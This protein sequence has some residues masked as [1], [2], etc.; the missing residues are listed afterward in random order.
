MAEKIFISILRVIR[1]LLI[2]SFLVCLGMGL[3]FDQIY[4][5]RID[6]TWA[7][8][9]L[10]DNIDRWSGVQIDREEIQKIGEGNTLNKIEM[11]I[12][13]QVL[14][15]FKGLS[16]QIA[17]AKQGINKEIDKTFWEE[18][19]IPDEFRVTKLDLSTEDAENFVV[20]ADGTN[21]ALGTMF[22]FKITNKIASISLGCLIGWYIFSFLW[23]IKE[24][25]FRTPSKI[26]ETADKNQNE[27]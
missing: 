17:Y 16:E 18:S 20:F 3:A 19:G 10:E 9:E 2:I 5:D 15:E 22:I 8:I 14:E 24:R 6:A 25:C 27:Q 23:W 1:V 21:S 12:N 7:Y 11:L 4:A 26:K 13:L